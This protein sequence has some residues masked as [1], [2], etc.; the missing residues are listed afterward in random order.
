MTLTFKANI[1]DVTYTNTKFNKFIKRL[2]Y[3]IYKH[4]WQKLKYIATWEKQKRGA[5]HY[6]IIFFDFPY[7][8]KPEL[9]CLWG[10]GFIHVNRIDVDSR[11]NRG[12]YVSK[13]FVKDLE[14]KEHKQKAFFKSQNLKHPLEQRLVLNGEGIEAL[15]SENVMF[16]K[17]YKRET[18]ISVMFRADDDE[19]D[20]FKDTS[21]RYLKIK[22]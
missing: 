6:H 20:V 16:S 12:R 14:L 3:F 18:Y 4:K 8:R 17:V 13:Y 5:I 19:P 21:V 11:E 15:E 1:T 22:K 10:H 9:E 7:I 2:N